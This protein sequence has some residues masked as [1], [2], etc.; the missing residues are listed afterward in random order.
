M[1]WRDF[2]F[3]PPRENGESGDNGAISPPIDPTC[4]PYSSYFPIVELEKSSNQGKKVLTVFSNEYVDNGENVNRLQDFNSIIANKNPLGRKDVCPARKLFA[5]LGGR[6][7][8]QDGV[9][10]NE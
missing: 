9:V 2:Q 7:I 4:S 5:G 10:H 6:I 1:G 3:L 8:G